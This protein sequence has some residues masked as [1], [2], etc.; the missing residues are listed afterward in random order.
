MKKLIK[1][2]VPPLLWDKLQYIRNYRHFVK[3]KGLIAKN[4]ELKDIHKG[5]RCFILGSGPSIKKEDLKPLKN[6]IVFALNNFYV[7]EDF[8]EIMSGDVPKYYITAPVHPP[9]TEDEWKRWFED[10]ELHMPKDTNMLFGLN[11]YDG[12][13]KYIFEKYGIF[14]E[15]KINWYFAG[16]NI[17]KE[18]VFSNR[19][20]DLMSPI[21]SASTVSTYALLIAIYMGFNE[22]YLLG[23]DHNYI[24]LQKEENF[25]FYKSAIHQQ[26]EHER[27]NYKKS[28][29]FFG[30]GKVFLEKELIATNCKSSQIINCSMESLLDMFEKVEF[31]KVLP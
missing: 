30:T 19:D 12:N 28:D 4:I 13:I 25:R 16:V 10:M 11:A 14:K 18:Y 22:I 6:E 23:V 27:M 7:H 20:I 31:K 21:W 3:Y 15:H 1:S 8:A 9:Q 29:E 24:C 26:N 5:K 17:S 2:I